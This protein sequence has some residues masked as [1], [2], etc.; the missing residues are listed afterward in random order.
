MDISDNTSD[1]YFRHRQ[2]SETTYEQYRLPVYLRSCLPDKNTRI[3]DIGCGFGQMLSALQREG[4]TH[5]SGIDILPEAVTHCREKNLNVQ[6]I[7]DLAEFASAQ[8]P[9]Y[10]VIVMSHV[11]EHLPKE[12][13]I[14]TLRLIRMNL[15]Q[16]GGGLLVM[17][18]NAQSNTGCY[19]AYEDFTHT[20]IFTA[21]SIYYV[22]KSAGFREV[23]FVDPLGTAGCR[24]LAGAV[25]RVLISLYRA[26]TS[27]WNKVT[28][29]SFHRP[30]PQI[31]TYELK[32][33]AR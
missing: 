14:S 10:D 21:G 12:A 1:A 22:L 13:I 20:T 32:V 4:F 18:P 33:L 7:T 11:L 19:W 9:G 16:P 17:V 28:G 2:I 29:S 15:L 31:F 6:L 26:K 25:K 8:S 3:L 5:L 30:S 24:P 23:E 27:F